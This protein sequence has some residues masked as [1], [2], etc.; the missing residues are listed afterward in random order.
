VSP[1]ARLLVTS[2]CSPLWVT[3][4]IE[5]G[6]ALASRG[7]AAVT[8]P[9]PSGWDRDRQFWGRVLLAKRIVY[10][11]FSS[12]LLTCRPMQ[13]AT[14]SLCRFLRDRGAD[15]QIVYLPGGATGARQDVGGFLA[16]GGTIEDA[17]RGTDRSLVWE[18]VAPE[19]LTFWNE[20]RNTPDGIVKTSLRK[21]KVTKELLTDF[22]AIIVGETLI[23]PGDDERREFDIELTKGKVKMTRR[24]TADEFDK[25]SFLI[26][27]F[28][29]G[30]IM[31]SGYNA[32]DGVRTAIQTISHA[33]GFPQ[34]RVYGHLGWTEH[35][36]KWFFL[37]AGGTIPDLR[38]V[39]D[40]SGYSN[41]RRRNALTPVSP[42]IPVIPNERVLVAVELPSALANYELPPPPPRSE[43]KEIFHR[44]LECLRSIA[45]SHVSLPLFAAALRVVLGPVDFGVF[46][47][48]VTGTGKSEL[49][50]WYTQF[51]GPRITAR[52][53]P[54]S[55]L[56]T[57]NAILETAHL[58][59]NVL[60]PVDDFVPGGTGELQK[61]HRDADR[62][63]RSQG[64]QAGRSRLSRDG[65]PQEGH[66]P[67]GM[68]FGTGEDVPLGHSVNARIWTVT[69]RPGD[70]IGPEKN[71]RL[72]ECQAFAAEG[73]LAQLMASYLEWLAPQYEQIADSV[74]RKKAKLREQFPEWSSFHTM[75]AHPRGPEMA[76]DLLAAL[77]IFIEFAM[78]RS[79]L[80]DL[81]VELLW[82][83]TA[84]A[85]AQHFEQNFVE[86]ADDDPAG[87]FLSSLTTALRTGTAHLR[88]LANEVPPKNPTEWGWLD[89][90]RVV[91]QTDDEAETDERLV[92]SH[93][94]R[95][96]QIGWVDDRYVYVDVAK[97]LAVAQNLARET[98]GARL[99]LSDRTLGQKLDDKGLL[100]DKET[101]R[102]T[103]KITVCG[104]QH[105]VLKLQHDA[106]GK[107][108]STLE[109]EKLEIRRLTW[110]EIVADL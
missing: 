51:F 14:A 62:L 11:A 74:T 80:T 110:Q 27:K 58:A 72:S 88:S 107:S 36:G 61:A 19:P 31:K 71:A 95:G 9:E 65:H 21:G 59:K 20:F 43:Q 7:L 60:F 34:T 42:M 48:G 3:S 54:G 46:I 29:P 10:S 35:E 100:F 16:N 105:R 6:D 53:L 93:L 106:F 94:P 49:A 96:A 24:V 39:P 38:R 12:D 5:N 104:R 69:L 103:T 52:H 18:A 84:A 17:L 64:N 15:P 76:A 97:S 102:Y 4:G 63:F 89:N 83:N 2:A 8:L 87:R 109:K 92:E 28:G 82:D 47:A 26:P 77:D 67:R 81:E 23:N 37:H 55:F 1:L 13:H 30:F 45:P 41:A 25:M 79:W 108:L 98:E 22:Q 91:V 66:A 86:R 90:S 57:P 70:V 32:R 33:A 101:G 75:T 78:E 40:P 99:Q 44:T 68:I 73:K 56:S 50:A 85:I